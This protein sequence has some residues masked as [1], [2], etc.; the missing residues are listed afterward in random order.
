M[1]AAA[2]SAWAD[3]TS[4]FNTGNEG[5]TSVSFNDLVKDDYG[6]KGNFSVTWTGSGGNPGGFISRTD[7]DGGVFTFSAP[8]AFLGDQS[9]MTQLQY[10]FKQLLGTPNYQTTDVILTGTNGTRL[11]W[12]SQPDFVPSL[13]AWKTVTVDFTP[14]ASWRV[15]SSSGPLATA[16]DF[17]RVLSHLSGLYIR[18]EYVNG[19]D[20]EGLDNIHLS[21]AVPEPGAWGLLFAGALVLSAAARRRIG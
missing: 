3:V 19:N 8:Q 9:K 10:D 12:K 4:T 20:T 17:S 6:I 13:Q 7:P 16:A 15:S 11:L 21:A 14:S 1:T 5:W 18:G 2:G